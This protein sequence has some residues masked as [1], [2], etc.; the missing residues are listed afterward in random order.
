MENDLTRKWI[1]ITS[2]SLGPAPTANAFG[3][4]RKHV[5]VQ[6]NMGNDIRV[7]R[8]KKM[9][10]CELGTNG[11]IGNAVCGHCARHTRG[12]YIFVQMT[13][14]LYVRSDTNHIESFETHFRH[15]HVS[16]THSTK[17]IDQ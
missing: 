8:I 16:V 9:G 15:H 5:E 10:K 1:S 3:C 13:A 11:S 12:K 7:T 17:R 14:K 6:R 2:L 4:L